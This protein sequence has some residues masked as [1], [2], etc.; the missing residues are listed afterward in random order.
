MKLQIDREREKIGGEGAGEGWRM[1]VGR[2]EEE[3]KGRVGEI[4]R[5]GEECWKIPGEAMGRNMESG[6]SGQLVTRAGKFQN[7]SSIV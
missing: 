5:E 3:R 7:H 1:V 4:K 2:I 6:S